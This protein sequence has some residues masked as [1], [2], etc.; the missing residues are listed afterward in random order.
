M[1]LEERKQAGRIIQNST[2]DHPVEV[3]GSLEA[4]S[5]GQDSRAKDHNL[6]VLGRK[7]WDGWT[8]CPSLL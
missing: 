6:G 1:Y 4:V 3:G 2:R 7:V 5:A 8:L